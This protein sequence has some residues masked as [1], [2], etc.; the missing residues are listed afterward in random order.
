[1]LPY[2]SPQKQKAEKKYLENHLGIK[3]NQEQ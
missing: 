3:E 1:M 2:R